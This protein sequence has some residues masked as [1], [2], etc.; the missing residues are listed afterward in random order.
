MFFRKKIVFIYLC[1]NS[2]Y[3]YSQIGGATTYSF[4]KLPVSARVTALGGAVISTK[5]N[6]LNMALTNP[7]LL[8]DT[9]NNNISLNYV[10]YFADVNY[11]NVAYARNIKKN[12]NMAFGI[13][14]LNY[15]KFT[16]ADEYGTINGTFGASDMSFNISYAR[17]VPVDSNLTCGATLKTIYSNMYN[18]TSW[19]SA[20]DIGGMYVIPKYNLGISAMIKNAGIQWK[21]YTPDSKREHLPFE[22]QLGCSKKLKHAPIRFSLTYQNLERWNMRYVDS[23]TA[24]SIKYFK[25][26]NFGNNLMRH[27]VIGAELIIAKNFF[28]RAGYNYQRREELKIDVKKGLTGFSIGFGLRI[29]KF[30]ISYGRA[31]YS[32]AGASNTFSVVFDINSFYQ[33]KQ[34]N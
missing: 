24:D 28:I 19:G 27:L 29:Y 30:Q 7:A 17:S 16:N 32:L 8:G 9:M 34:A 31:A 3:C 26:K 5:D 1:F 20:I 23:A 12:Q 33:K 22:M 25:A 2:V 4:L 15:G 13:Q 14:Y 21:R 10:N 6:D 18:T 11:G